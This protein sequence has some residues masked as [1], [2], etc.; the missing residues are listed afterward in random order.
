MFEREWYGIFCGSTQSH[1]AIHQLERKICML[2]V[3]NDNVTLRDTP[4]R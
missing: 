2:Y 3:I 1:S 4:E